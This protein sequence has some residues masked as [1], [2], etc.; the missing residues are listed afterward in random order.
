MVMGQNI[1][2]IMSDVLSDV[3]GVVILDVLPDDKSD[4][5]HLFYLFL[6]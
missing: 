3:M 2:N 6:L 4:L 1:S 5:L